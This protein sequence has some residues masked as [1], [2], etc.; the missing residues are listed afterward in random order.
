MEGGVGFEDEGKGFAG[1]AEGDV[2]V[3]YGGGGVGCG[4]GPGEG[5]D[6]GEV[7]LGGWHASLSCVIMCEGS[8]MGWK[9]HIKCLDLHS[10]VEV[11]LLSLP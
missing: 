8:G 4:G 6:V 10:R 9:D 7:D 11:H 5:A 2:V 3:Y 1:G